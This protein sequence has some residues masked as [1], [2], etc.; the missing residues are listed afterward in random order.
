MI[1]NHKLIL[2]LLFISLSMCNQKQTPEQIALIERI[3]EIIGFIVGI[4]FLAKYLPVAQEPPPRPER[5]KRGLTRLE[6]TEMSQTN[7]AIKKSK[8][9]ASGRWIATK[10]HNFM[11]LL[12]AIANLTTARPRNSK[13]GNNLSH[14]RQPKQAKLAFFAISA[15]DSSGVLAYYKRPCH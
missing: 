5:A 2:M 10:N 11:Y 1:K 6:Q 14:S 8:C 12:T 15:G 7:L 4:Y 13:R 3:S 9:K